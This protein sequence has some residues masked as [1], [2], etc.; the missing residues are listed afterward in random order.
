MEIIRL[1]AKKIE[2]LHA[3]E[4]DNHLYASVWC[5]FDKEFKP[6][7]VVLSEEEI[8]EDDM[9]DFFREEE[10]YRYKYMYIIRKDN[11][12]AYCFSDKGITC[13]NG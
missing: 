8:P 13:L 5:I 7:R 4:G 3:Q 2:L 10:R 1:T 11:L 9:I 12:V 6:F